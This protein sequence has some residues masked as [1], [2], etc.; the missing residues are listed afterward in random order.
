MSLAASF[1][2]SDRPLTTSNPEIALLL[3]CARS[4]TNSQHREQ[5]E[6]LLKQQIDWQYLIEVATRHKLLP[7]L[8][9]NLSSN[10]I[11]ASIQD[12]DEKQLQQAFQLNT[13]RN[14]QLTAELIKTLS[15]LKENGIE[16]VSVK[17]PILAILAYGKYG[18]RIVSDLDIIVRP[19]DF[20]KAQQLLI[21]A[22]YK[23][24]PINYEAYY[25]QAQYYK[26]S[27]IKIGI[28]LHYEFAPKNHFATVDSRVFWQNLVTYKLASQEVK[29]FSLEY[30]II[31]L[32]LEGIKEHWRWLNR[33]CDLSELVKNQHP[34]WNLLLTSAETLQ[35]KEVVLLGLYLAYIVLDT[36][37]PKFIVEEIDSCFDY[38]IDKEQIYKFLFRKKFSLTIA[39]KWYLF[40][41][42]GFPQTSARINYL[43]AVIKEKIAAKN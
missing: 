30:S 23:P 16:A 33:L 39:I 41:A 38:L 18:L 28:D 20:A 21:S 31:H 2:K 9:A 7:L 14:L 17:G 27:N 6:T 12:I 40:L 5:I 29:I 19:K 13:H 15:Y 43:L 22:Q 34:D 1:R 35:K 42:Q 32:C 3:T 10:D 37:L 11:K 36:P 8:Y 25:Q 26:A 24:N 4:Q